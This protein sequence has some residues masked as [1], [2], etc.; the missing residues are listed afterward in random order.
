MQIETAG[1]APD[2][3][4]L[5]HFVGNNLLQLQHPVMAAV[6]QHWHGSDSTHRADPRAKV[7]HPA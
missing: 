7:P 6:R 1:T 5:T 2:V 4:R 3:Q